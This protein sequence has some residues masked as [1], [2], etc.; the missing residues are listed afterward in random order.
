MSGCPGV[1]E[2]A[3]ASGEGSLR[4]FGDLEEERSRRGKR[5][6]GS[7]GGKKLAPKFFS[8]PHT[9][10]SES[11][12]RRPFVECVSGCGGGAPYPIG[13]A[14]RSGTPRARARVYAEIISPLKT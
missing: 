13:G 5:G 7:V 10:S 11:R 4:A 6:L 2:G 1:G 9:Q 3:F 8:L 12:P 14:D